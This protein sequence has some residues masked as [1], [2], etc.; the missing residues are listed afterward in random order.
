MGD[1]GQHLLIYT[2]EPGSPAWQALELLASWRTTSARGRVET[3]W[4]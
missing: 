3:L 2:A 1:P 4:G